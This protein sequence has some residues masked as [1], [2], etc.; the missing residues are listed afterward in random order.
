MYGTEF[1]KLSTDDHINDNQLIYIMCSSNVR[2]A[3]IACEID[4][5]LDDDRY[6][7]HKPRTVY[8][9]IPPQPFSACISRL[10]LD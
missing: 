10:C 7:V 4:R 3:C 5:V 6:M 8:V 9:V 1:S 2:A